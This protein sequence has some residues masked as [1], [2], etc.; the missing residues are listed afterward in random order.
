MADLARKKRIRA[1]H[2]AS[3]TKTMTKIDAALTAEPV[4]VS[5]LPLL[6]LTLKEKLEVI[7]TLDSEVIE[8]I[9]EEEALTTEIQQADEYRESIHSYLLRIEA[10]LV[11]ATPPTSGATGPIDVD[12]TAPSTSTTVKLPRLKLRAFAGDLTQWTPFWESFEAAVHTNSH[13]T[14]VE[15]FNYLNSVVEGTAQE[16][17]AGLS[18]TAANYEQAVTTLKKRFGSKQNIINKHMDAMLNMGSVFSCT[19]V[20]GLQHLFDQVSS[21]VRSLKSLDVGP[22]AYGSLLCPV[23]VAKLPSELQLIVSRKLSEEDWNLDELLR[24]IEEEVVARERVS[25]T[26]TVKPRR[27]NKPPPSATALVSDAKVFKQGC[28]Y[29][30]KDHFPANCDVVPEVGARKQILRKSGRCFSCLRKGHLSRNCR[31]TRRCHECNGRH[32]TSICTPRQVPTVEMSS[33]TTPVV[34]TNTLNPSAPEYIPSTTN[35]TLYL[36]ANRTVLLQTA[37]AE[38]YNPIDK[39]QRRSIRIVMDSGNQRSYLTTKVKQD[40]RLESVSTQQLSIAAFGSRRAQVKSCDVVTLKIQTRFGPDLQVHLFV[41]PHICD[42]L[43]ARPVSTGYQH[44]S[45]LDLADHCSESELLEVDLLIGSDVYWDIV[46]GE[47]VRGANGPV[48]INT[49]LGWVLSGPAQTSD[50]TSVNYTSI[51]T[52]RIDGSTDVLEKELQSFWEL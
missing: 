17:I 20:K 51:H 13:L 52:L 27:D 42:P 36:E 32:H 33:E 26:Q 1:G 34:T 22:E 12:K 19:D 45:G 15:K 46:T 47:V 48:A 28:C 4:A 11:P 43:S 16:A 40:L 14:P 21:H 24:V 7:R 23:L 39:T 37:V 6:K 29:C 31:T 10:A 50:V 18:L 35:T 2:K 8:L 9:E 44:L 25:V 3:V 38:V 5:G 41:V 49:T 30:D